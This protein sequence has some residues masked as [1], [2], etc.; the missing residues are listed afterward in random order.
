MPNPLCASRLAQRCF[1]LLA[2]SIFSH[3]AIAGTTGAGSGGV[4][5]WER[6]L[7]TIADSLTGPVAQ[8]LMLIAIAALGFAF[9]FSEPGAMRRVLAVVFGGAIA[10][11]ATTLLST[12]FGTTAGATF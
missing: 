8:A 5:S 3:A 12:F 7:R 2:L 6:A 10:L 11:N 1:S 4:G 9:A